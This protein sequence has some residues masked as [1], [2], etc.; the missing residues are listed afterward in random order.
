MNNIQNYRNANVNLNYGKVSKSPNFKAKFGIKGISTETL[1]DFLKS[2]YCKT[3]ACSVPDITQG[4]LYEF[5]RMLEFVKNL[6]DD[7]VLMFDKDFQQ[8]TNLKNELTCTIKEPEIV[9]TGNKFFDSMIMFMDKAGFSGRWNENLEEESLLFL[10]KNEGRKTYKELF[11]TF[12]KDIFADD[13]MATKDFR[14]DYKRREKVV[15]T[16]DEYGD[17]KLFSYL[18]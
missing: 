15:I 4:K 9:V 16:E 18:S 2:H 3:N 8:I 17:L 5:K 6:P 7:I 1:E 14:S 11:D 10:N 12:K 13:T